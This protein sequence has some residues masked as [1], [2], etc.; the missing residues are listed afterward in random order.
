MEQITEKINDLFVSWGFDSSEVGP[1]MT[2]VL[3]IGIAFLADLICRNIL[4]RVVAKLVKKTKATWDDIVFDRKVVPPI[5]IYV[6]IPLA[7]PNV[8]ALDFIRRICMIYIIAV[9]LRFISAFLSAVYHVYSER[10]QFRDRPLKG[11][12]QTAQ[13]I[14]FF[15]GGIVVI[16]VLIDKSPMV[17]LTGLGARLPS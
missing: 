3:I 11:L 6:L 16:S 10:E 13:V 5:I 8:S 9:F 1:I 17:L 14:L 7:I 2:L 12:L 15:I 4:L